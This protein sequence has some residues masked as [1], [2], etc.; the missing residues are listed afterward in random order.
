MCASRST[1]VLRVPHSAIEPC[2]PGKTSVEVVPRRRQAPG[3]PGESEI[4]ERAE[5]GE[6]VSHVRVA[7]HDQV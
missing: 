5:G 4:P 3:V 7:G 2:K 6:P 1:F